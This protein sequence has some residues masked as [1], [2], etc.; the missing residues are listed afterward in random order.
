MKV[1]DLVKSNLWHEEE[2]GIVTK[3]YLASGRWVVVY[4]FNTKQ[5]RH[6]NPRKLMVFNESR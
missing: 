4:W 6:E 5:H 3:Q 1:G 2:I